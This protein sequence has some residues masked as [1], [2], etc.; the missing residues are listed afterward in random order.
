[1]ADGGRR[2]SAVVGIWIG[3][4]NRPSFR[5][6]E[7]A[8]PADFLAETM[9]VAGRWKKNWEDSKFSALWRFGQGASRRFPDALRR[10]TRR[11]AANIAQFVI[12]LGPRR[13]ISWVRTEAKRAPGRPRCLSVIVLAPARCAPQMCA[14]RVHIEPV[15]A[16][17][18]W[19][20]LVQPRQSLP[21]PRTTSAGAHVVLS[22]GMTAAASGFPCLCKS[23]CPPAT[24]SSS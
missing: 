11:T 14:S 5:T 10:R 4:V 24:G 18:S 13:S 15:R 8:E 23:H 16:D 7:S 2:T 17:L 20:Q 6:R 12:M 3:S 19:I 21:L 1:M 9:S 22:M